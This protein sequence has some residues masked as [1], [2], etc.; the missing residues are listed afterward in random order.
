METENGRFIAERIRQLA[1][2]TPD[3]RAYTILDDDL[4][5]AAR[6]TYRELAQLATEMASRIRQRVHVG[7]RV[8]LVFPTGMDFLRALYGCLVAGVI[9]VPAYPP[10]SAKGLKKL[11]HIVSDCGA[12]LVL[13][14]RML[15]GMMQKRGIALAGVD[16]ESIDAIEALPNDPAF[17]PLS[18]E[19]DQPA[20][21]QYSSGSTRDPRGVI[22][23]HRMLAHNVDMM[24]R[25][26]Q[27][28][29]TSIFVCWL[30]LYHDL[31]LIGNVL[32]SLTVGGHTILMSPQ[33]FIRRPENWLK[34]ISEYR[35][36]FSGTPNFGYEYVLQR[37]GDPSNGGL[38]LSS[39]RTAFSGAEPI[40]A[41]TIRRFAERYAAAGFNDTTMAPAFGL[42][43]TGVFVSA[44]DPGTRPVIANFSRAHYEQ[45]R[46][47]PAGSCESTVELVGCGWSD[48]GQSIGIFDPESWRPLTHGEI[49]IIG[50][51]GDHVTP[52][53]WGR[54][55]SIH[56]DWDGARYVNT[57]DLGFIHN[58]QLYIAGR[59]KDVLIVRGRNL[60][61]QDIEAHVEENCP[62]LRAGCSAALSVMEVDEPDAIDL[63]LEVRH[64]LDAGAADALGR[65]IRK[66]LAGHFDVPV[67]RIYLFEPKSLPKTSSGKIQRSRARAE[68]EAG[69]IKPL[70][71]LE[72]EEATAS[73]GSADKTRQDKR[74]YPHD[75]D[76]G[77]EL[78]RH[79]LSH[80][81]HRLTDEDWD[82]SFADIGISSIH[83]ADILVDLE[84][85][86][87]V[88]LSE[89]KLVGLPTLGDLALYVGRIPT[90]EGRVATP[91]A[92]RGRGRIEEA[93]L[94]NPLRDRIT[95]LGERFQAFKRKGLYA[96]N[97]KIERSEGKTVWVG[98]KPMM[99]LSSYCSLG[100]QDHPK[101]KEAAA[102]A[103]RRWGAGHHG[104]RP[105]LGTTS[106]HEAF[107]AKLA[108][109][110]GCEA[111]IVYSSGYVTNVSTIDALLEPSDTVLLDEFCHASIYDGCRISGANQA[112]F[113]HNDLGHLGGL[114]ARHAG[115]AP[116][117]LVDSVFSMEG[118]V[119]PLDR[120]TEIA[121]LSGVP[122]MIDEAHG[123][124]TI[125][126]TGRGLVEHFGL[127]PSSVY[128][129]MGTLSKAIGCDGGFVAGEA[130]LIDYLRH[131]ARGYIFSGASSVGSLGAADAALD[132]L[133]EESWR[134][135]R[136]R[137]LAPILRDGL[138]GAG[139]D[140]G[141]SC[142]HIVPII[143]GSDELTL[144]FSLK[145]RE[146]GLFATPV[147]YPAVPVGKARL[148]TCVN[149][150]LEPGDIGI[151][152]ELI[153]RAARELGYRAGEL[154]ETSAQAAV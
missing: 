136:L 151:A 145:L 54:D 116:L 41:Q 25:K 7:E 134:V 10:D 33:T 5:E 93:G 125:G 63:A 92:T 40:R 126:K 122:L 11:A 143:L 59:K 12:R 17:V 104:V 30:P 153:L 26:F 121:E 64:K 23:T 31:G 66:E 115:R 85:K 61:P 102:S 137:E 76:P 78:I 113:R 108:A 89:E 114:L 105:L 152:L 74:P 48:H 94:Q 79:V 83:V 109:F 135:E 84:E 1:E 18:P 150:A 67:R 28:D 44:I 91:P 51:S 107:E 131:H 117:I 16:I 45:G 96:W 132:V 81:G 21:L 120:L 148:R 47:V 58:G 29:A 73:A 22:V 72:Q 147:V 35:G 138:R 144:R 53:Y 75:S 46:A 110:L 15:H 124:G 20:F 77:Y 90:G 128:V 71:V 32:H 154:R 130:G 119:A 8:V 6:C 68:I 56:F 36:T 88:T 49:G 2:T 97:P 34:A 24:R 13:T 14:D 86:L 98:G 101:L 19:P 4:N 146:L 27:T 69:E 106:L 43:E 70:Y 3:A 127:K 95:L 112:R 140:V 82:R 129:R 103:L 57:G 149:S 37:L 118:D 141:A 123:F 60:Y 9:P 139:F 62:E 142:T 99:N 87:A 50:I 133:E 38:D 52:G 55:E 111:A 42:A 100:L 39:W 80:H 65:R